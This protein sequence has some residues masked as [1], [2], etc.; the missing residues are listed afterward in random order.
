MFCK[1]NQFLFLT[2]NEF[3]IIRY[4]NVQ[5]II[6][7]HFVLLILRHTHIIYSEF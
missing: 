3:T 4:V 2:R 5:S 6:P 7:L 1:F